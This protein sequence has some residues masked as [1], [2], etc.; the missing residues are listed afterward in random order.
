MAFECCPSILHSHAL[1]ASRQLRQI[2]VEPLHLQLLQLLLSLQ[3]TRSALHT[4]HGLPLADL[5]LSDLDLSICALVFKAWQRIGKR[6]KVCDKLFIGPSSLLSLR[7]RFLDL[8][9]KRRVLDLQ[10]VSL[11]RAE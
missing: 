3:R 5:C 11:G 7:G 2:L 10:F 4:L 6:L 9:D 1:C 8:R